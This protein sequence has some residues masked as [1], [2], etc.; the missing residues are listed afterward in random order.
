MRRRAPGLQ[1]VAAVACVAAAAVSRAGG[2]GPRYVVE[3]DRVT[4]TL[5]APP[6]APVSAEPPLVIRRERASQQERVYYSVAGP[7]VSDRGGSIPPQ[8]VR[9]VNEYGDPPGWSHVL[10]LRGGDRSAAFRVEVLPEA[11]RDDGDPSLWR[12]AGRYSGWLASEVFGAPAIPV[13]VE[14]AEYQTATAVPD[15][16]TVTVQA[17]PLDQVG[18]S[19]PGTYLSEETVTVTV[20]AN[21]PD[22]RLWWEFVPPSLQGEPGRQIPL[23]RL[24]L[25]ENGGPFRPVPGGREVWFS[26]QAL[27]EP[28]R[29]SRTVR[30]QV[31]L[32]WED[33]PGH[34]TGSMLLDLDGPE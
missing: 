26:G 21:H 33:R 12:Y 15:Q 4:V 31:E 17:L 22:W 6:N 14:L 18:P 24:A 8:L 3:P 11:W 27:A 20:R 30:L 23:E 28:R 5:A 2:P 32:R 1:W 16:F 10:V 7:L 29:H 25:S 34:Y 9:I 13:T 19:G